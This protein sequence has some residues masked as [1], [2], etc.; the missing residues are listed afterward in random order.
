M[1]QTKKKHIYRDNTGVED[2]L[3]IFHYLKHKGTQSSYVKQV[4]SDL[5]SSVTA[6]VKVKLVGMRDVRIHSSTSGN[7]STTSNLTK[8][9]QFT[10]MVFFLCCKLK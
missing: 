3:V 9:N 10:L 6:E 4:E 8:S 7:V 2:S 1:K 5:Y